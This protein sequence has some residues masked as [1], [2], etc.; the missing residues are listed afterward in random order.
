M[1]G[2]RTFTALVGLAA[3]VAISVV[4]YVHLD[5]LF[6]FLF[7]PFVPLLFGGRRDHGGAARTCPQCGFTTRSSE[8]RYC[9]RDGTELRTE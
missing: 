7:L 9:P 2:S 8:A 3:S 6:V 5:T 1:V 4:A